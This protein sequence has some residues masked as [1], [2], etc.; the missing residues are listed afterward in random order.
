MIYALLDGTNQI[1][2][3]HLEA[4]LS[5]WEF[6]EA[7]A[8]HIFG[9]LIGE[10]LADEILRSLRG[11]GPEGMTRTDLHRLFNRHQTSASIGAALGILMAAGMVRREQRTRNRSMETGGR[12]VEVWVAT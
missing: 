3:P 12:P 11:V 9:D 10:P 2:L 8:K 1:D 4:A 6:C 7:S 5:V